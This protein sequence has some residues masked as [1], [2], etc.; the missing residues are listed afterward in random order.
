MTGRRIK[1]TLGYDGT[2]YAGWQRQKNGPSVQ[3]TIE[4]ALDRLFH[5]GTKIVGSG[6]TD[7]GVHAHAQVAAFTL[8]HPIPCDSL[9]LALNSNL[10]D[11]IRIYRA[12]EVNADFHPQFQA[13]QKTYRYRFYEG[14]VLP[15]QLRLYTVQVLP[16]VDW[17]KVEEALPL[18]EGTHDFACCCASGSVASE[19]VRTIFAAKLLREEEGEGIYTLELTGNGFLYNM[20]RILAGTLLEIGRDRLPAEALREALLDGERSKLGATAPA[21]GLELWKVEY[22]EN[23]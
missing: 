13:K 19:T 1:L 15:T 5:E 22:P 17:D 8:K 16:G 12:E 2:A 10:P 11:D 21:K 6:R 9:L 20:V 23:D 18:I 14:D 3:E 7:A 4:A